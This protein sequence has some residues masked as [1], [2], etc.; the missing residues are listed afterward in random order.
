M[1]Q[2]I[3]AVSQEFDLVI[4]DT[5]PIS[6]VADGLILSKLADGIMLVVRPGAVNSTA[7]INTRNILEQSGETV[8][9]MV[10]NGVNT[11]MNYGSYYYVDRH[12]KPKQNGE[13]STKGKDNTRNAEAVLKSLIG[14]K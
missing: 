4:I 8:L 5:P 6:V 13:A 11:K 1:T 9:G 14:R 7:L 2:V 12:Q 10:A 3:E